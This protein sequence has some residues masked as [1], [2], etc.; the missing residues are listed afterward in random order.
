MAAC[1]KE[2]LHNEGIESS[3]PVTFSAKALVDDNASTKTTLSGNDKDGYDVVWSSG[4]DFRLLYKYSRQYSYWGYLTY[5]ISSGSGS[6]TAEFT[7]TDSFKSE[8]FSKPEICFYPASLV[9]DSIDGSTSTSIS[10]LYWPESQTYIAGTASRCPM[11]SYDTDPS[12]T[13]TF[14]NLGGV[15][16]L[17]VKGSGKITSIR[18]SAGQKM[19]GTFRLN[20]EEAP[21]AVIMEYPEG[22][23]GS[24]VLDCGDGVQLNDKGVDFHFNIPAGSYTG[25]KVDFFNGDLKIG[26][27]KAKKD[28][29]IERS[30][31]TPAVM[32]APT[33]SPGTLLN[34][35]RANVIAA[36]ELAEL[37]LDL[38]GDKI[39]SYASFLSFLLPFDLIIVP[40]SY[41]TNDVDGN[42][43]A[44]SG[45][46]AY[47]DISADQYGTF[48]LNRIVS[49]QHGTCDINE[50]PS[51]QE[52]PMELLPAAVGIREGSSLIELLYGQYFVACMADYL[53]YGLTEN[54]SLLHPYLH[55]KLTGSTCADM[56]TATEEYI[57]EYGLEVDTDRVDLV[58]YSQ[59]GAATISTMLE[60]LDRD[61]GVWS[62]R[63]GEVWAGAGPYDIMEFMN[64]FSENESY[65]RS[66][67]IP[68]A[69]RGL[70][71]GEGL[72]I[73]WDNVY[74]A[75]IGGSGKGGNQLEAELFS[76]TQVSTWTDVIGTD[77]K[78]ILSPDF[79]A[80]G[81][82]GNRD[83]ISLENAAMANS[84]TNCTAPDAAMKAKI[85]LYHSPLDDTVPFGCS[86]S[87]QEAWGLDEINELA[88]SDHVQ[89][90]VDFL[91][92]FCGISSIIDNN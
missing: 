89:A 12:G 62:S 40:V 82:N 79:Y 51:K 28:I 32:T 31:I 78:K 80:E 52:L 85:K 37:A 29:V 3:L 6:T 34:V 90:G 56:I 46:I 38:A 35:E 68:Y 23:D 50:A 17:T 81:R 13:F 74:N 43:V 24:I 65:S 33:L 71:Y 36:S 87:L 92:T 11:V 39:G 69:F 66:C 42:L 73:D 44:A 84:V 83:I 64:Y 67:Y 55:N 86:T 54:S 10:P 1:T 77:V 2:P 18:I 19:S 41:A 76:K 7:T 58:G 53:G 30:R 63:I 26:T 88:P 15:L 9:P 14:K 8:D 57:Q 48:S 72:D 22:E 5:S 49:I 70:A 45:L 47:P 60:L 59:G 4:D 27:R 25:L 91:L 16:R 61:K 75:S 21:G 20:T